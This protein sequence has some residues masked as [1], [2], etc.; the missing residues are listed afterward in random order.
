M[1]YF[2]IT[3]IVKGTFS[4]TEESEIVSQFYK[5][6]RENNPHAHVQFMDLPIGATENEKLWYADLEI[7]FDEWKK[8]STIRN[9]DTKGEE[10]AK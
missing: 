6:D 9:K 7:Y 1:E 4:S 5:F 3:I 2:P 8:N 10:K